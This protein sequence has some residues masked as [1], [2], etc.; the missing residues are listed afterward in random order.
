MTLNSWCEISA[1]P[2]YSV[3]K[4]GSTL[5]SSVSVVYVG[6]HWR[7]TISTSTSVDTRGIPMMA[8]PHRAVSSLKWF[9]FNAIPLWFILNDG[10]SRACKCKTI[11]V[12]FPT[13]KINAPSAIITSIHIRI[14][15]KVV[16]TQLYLKHINP[17]LLPYYLVMFP[18]RVLT[19]AAVCVCMQWNRFL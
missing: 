7:R 19:K 3:L 16:I 2:F 18:L 12:V 11:T 10:T 9:L 8:T 15:L 13:I 4:I 6:N 5:P 14:L 1:T 17:S